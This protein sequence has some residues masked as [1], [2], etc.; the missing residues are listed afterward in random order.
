[1][2]GNYP[3][4]RRPNQEDTTGFKYRR[5]FMLRKITKYN[6]AVLR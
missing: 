1:M 3:E 5:A 2:N 4:W 6:P